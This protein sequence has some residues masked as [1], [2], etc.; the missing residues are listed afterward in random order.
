MDWVSRSWQRS[1]GRVANTA[2]IPRYLEVV[3]G[4]VW[5][6]GGREC[7]AQDALIRLQVVVGWPVG[8]IASPA[9][10]GFSSFSAV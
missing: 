9:Y 7:V 6:D 10:L 5:R 2:Q 8:R 1:R 4:R 3:V